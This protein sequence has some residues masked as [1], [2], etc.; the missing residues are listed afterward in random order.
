MPRFVV[1][2]HDWPRLHWDLMLEN[3]ANLRTWRLSEVPHPRHPI[4]LVRLPPHRSIY[5][6]YEG[7]VS[8]NRGTV[9]R[10]LWGTYQPVPA[11]PG[12]A[13][14]EFDLGGERWHGQIT[15]PAA[16]PEHASESV[17]PSPEPPGHL[18]WQWVGGREPG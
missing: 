15:G 7:P 10:V 6:D 9:K 2:Q 17:P 3:G 8:G 11:P 12:T 14:F 16:A 13:A 5:L 4:A 18:V 1:L